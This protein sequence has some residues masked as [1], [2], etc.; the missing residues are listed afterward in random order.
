VVQDDAAIFGGHL[1]AALGPLTIAALMTPVRDLPSGIVMVL[2]A[3][4]LVVAGATSLGGP[5]AG[6][7]ATVCA[8]LSTDFLYVRPYLDLKY[9]PEGDLW[10]VAFIVLT[11]LAIVAASWR[12]WRRRSAVATVAA[13]D[14]DV[15]PSRH[16]DRIVRLIGEDT[17]VRDLISA[18]QAELTSLLLARSCRFEPDGGTPVAL[19]MERNGTVTGHGLDPVLPPAELEIPVRLAEHQLGRFVVEPTP[20]VI[21]PL[22]PRLVAVMLTDHLATVIA[23]AHRPD[24]PGHRPTVPPPTDR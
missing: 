21:V 1:V 2:F 4:T 14:P 22:A 24:S 5:A 19:R 12:G 15:S 23:R 6:L 7:I 16:I 18:V 17:D 11:G 9:R 13:V 8:G 20:D 3:L 10:P